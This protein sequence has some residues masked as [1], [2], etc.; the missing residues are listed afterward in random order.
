MDLVRRLLAG[1]MLA[2][3]LA[4]GPARAAA[5]ALTFGL[6]PYLTPQRLSV[7]LRPLR[8]HLAEAGGQPL[9]LASAP[10]Y[11]QFRD[12]MLAGDFDL[13]FVAPHFA[14]TAE[15]EA[16]FRSVAMTRYRISAHVVVPE[17]ATI[18][19][20]AD[21]HGKR[22]AVPPRDSLI[23]LMA[24]Q[25]LRAEKLE[26]GRDVELVEFDTNENALAAPVRGNTDAGV[27]GNLVFQRLASINRMRSVVQT[28][29]VPG[30]MLMAHPRVA[31]ELIER[32]RAAALRFGDT[33]AGRVSLS[34]TGYGA[35][36]PFDPAELRTL[37]ARLQ[38]TS[39]Q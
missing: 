38:L 24:V 31:S 20:L 18:R 28:P 8:D 16:G 10:G 39:A 36:V 6:F 12:R 17:G 29:S 34:E 22:L 15:R 7:A 23:Y 1:L 4:P 30:F 33:P 13:V 32:W 19:S 27:T 9:R 2:L 35:W 25:L 37:D 3:Y 21:L 11:A 26:P 14:A 5:D